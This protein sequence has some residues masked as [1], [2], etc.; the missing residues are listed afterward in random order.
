MVAN[1]TNWLIIRDSIEITSGGGDVLILYSPHTPPKTA[2]FK[3]CLLNRYVHSE[4]HRILSRE[5]GVSPSLICRAKD[6]DSKS[7][8]DQRYSGKLTRRHTNKNLS[9]RS[10]RK[11]LNAFRKKLKGFIYNHTSVKS[12]D[13]EDVHLCGIS[14]S[15]PLCHFH[16]KSVGKGFRKNDLVIYRFF[17]KPK[18][19]KGNNTHAIRSSRNY[20]VACYYKRFSLRLR[21]T[22]LPIHV[23]AFAIRQKSR[24]M[25]CNDSCNVTTL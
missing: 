24:W 15:S 22:Y 23:L 11:K 8:L 6:V 20:C 2:H 25:E 17:R 5:C 21:R 4:Y 14:L 9:N 7:T 3:K 10:K 16:W 1:Y 13:S 19:T 12:V 18:K